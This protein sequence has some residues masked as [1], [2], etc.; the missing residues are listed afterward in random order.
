MSS[1]KIRALG[2]VKGNEVGVEKIELEE[3]L[4]V[5]DG[6]LKGVVRE[7]VHAF[8][9]GGAKV[10]IVFD[11]TNVRE[12]IRIMTQFYGIEVVIDLEVLEGF[13]DGVDTV[14]KGM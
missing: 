13:D 7:V 12:G 5:S 14:P 3:W 8:K 11:S 6:L 10:V 9:V 1:E 2:M 4:S